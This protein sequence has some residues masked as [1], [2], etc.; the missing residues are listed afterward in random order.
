[1]IFDRR[2]DRR[3]KN[4][5]IAVFLKG[6]CSAIDFFKELHVTECQRIH[7]V[8]VC[9]E[10]PPRDPRKASNFEVFLRKTSK[11]EAFLGSPS[12]V[13]SCLVLSCSSQL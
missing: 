5:K 4:I 1:M 10:R 2:N 9:A 12:T 8:D 6:K 7:D 3:G 13:L 11:F